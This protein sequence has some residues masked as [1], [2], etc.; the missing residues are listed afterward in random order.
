MATR[1]KGLFDLEHLTVDGIVRPKL[2]ED[3][4]KAITFRWKAAET[5]PPDLRVMRADLF[6][7]MI[8][9]GRS[10][11]EARKA[12]ADATTATILR[13]LNEVDAVALSGQ[14]ALRKATRRSAEKRSEK[15]ELR[16]ER[17]RGKYRSLQ[18]AGTPWGQLVGKTLQWAQ[19]QPEF[20]GI[21]RK[22]VALYCNHK[23]KGAS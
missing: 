18:L 14:R 8:K 20:A 10:E 7:A 16:A 23:K 4:R 1:S 15:A 13:F 17:I 22:T 6:R 3:E 2:T 19:R 5:S 9:A 21:A 12:S 11:D